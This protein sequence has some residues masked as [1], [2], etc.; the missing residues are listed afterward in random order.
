MINYVRGSLCALS[1]D[2]AQCSQSPEWSCGVAHAHLKFSVEPDIFFWILQ[3][4]A[5]VKGQILQQRAYKHQEQQCTEQCPK[6]KSYVSIIW[7]FN[8]FLV[9]FERPHV[10]SKE[11]KTW[12]TSSGCGPTSLS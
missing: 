8:V 4:F 6:Q 2:G 3:V 10:L 5:N 12:H 11:K 7:F 1:E 9:I